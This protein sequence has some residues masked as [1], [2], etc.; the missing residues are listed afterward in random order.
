MAQGT[1]FKVM[2][3]PGWEEGLGE[4]GCVYVSVCVL[5]HFSRVQLCGT[6]WN[7]AR[8]APRPWD[9]PGKNTGGGC[10]A[11][12]QGFL[13]TQESNLRL[14]R[15]PALACGLFTVST[16]WEVQTYVHIWLNSFAVHLKLSQHCLPIG[17][18]PIQNKNFK[19]KPTVLQ[20]W[21][22]HQRSRKNK[23]SDQWKSGPCPQPPSRAPRVAASSSM[24]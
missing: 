4:N 12:L 17:Y 24:S 15:L 9:S 6:L 3:Q 7:A 2:W 16:A 5:S 23:S 11:L 14:L 21:P 22:R 10:H 19:N 1:L 13:L 18:T 20:L 8:Q